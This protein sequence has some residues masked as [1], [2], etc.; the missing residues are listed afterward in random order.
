MTEKG[1]AH[2]RDGEDLR[3]LHRKHL[4]QEELKNKIDFVLKKETKGFFA[5]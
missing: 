5:T 4:D 1:T 2:G 3:I